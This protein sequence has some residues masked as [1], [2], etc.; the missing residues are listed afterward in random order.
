MWRESNPGVMVFARLTR[1]ISRLDE[2]VPHTRPPEVR[3][4]SMP[5]AVRAKWF[6]NRP[7]SRLW[8]LTRAAVFLLPRRH[9]FWGP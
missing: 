1:Q 4:E 9:R 7:D 2:L 5:E 8:S 3:G 6:S